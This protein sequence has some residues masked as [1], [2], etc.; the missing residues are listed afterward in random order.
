MYM[1]FM[2]YSTCNEKVGPLFQFEQAYK[3]LLQNLTFTVQ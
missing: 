1:N 2:V 3:S